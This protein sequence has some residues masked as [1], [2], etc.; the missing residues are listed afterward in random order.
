MSFTLPLGRARQNGAKISKTARLISS[1]FEPMVHPP[2]LP[3]PPLPLEADG[4]LTPP[5]EAAACRTAALTFRM[6]APHKV[7]LQV[8]PPGKE[9]AVPLRMLRTSVALKDGLTA[10]IKEIVPET[11]GAATLVPATR[12]AM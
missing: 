2:P 1:D 3:P 5:E 12:N 10:S 8:L 4:A 11:W 9:R 6:P 7:V